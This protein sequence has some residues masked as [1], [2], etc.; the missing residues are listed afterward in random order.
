MRLHGEGGNLD[1]GLEVPHLD[2]LLAAPGE[3]RLRDRLRTVVDPQHARRRF[4][5]R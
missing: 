5:A 2:L 3:E 1:V 4:A